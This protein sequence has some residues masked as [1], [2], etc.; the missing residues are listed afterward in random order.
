MANAYNHRVETGTG[1]AGSPNEI[2]SR[3]ELILEVRLALDGAIRLRR[4]VVEALDLCI[5]GGK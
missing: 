3:L 5:C 4:A 2:L 1:E